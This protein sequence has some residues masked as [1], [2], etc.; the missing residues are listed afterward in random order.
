MADVTLQPPAGAAGE[1]TGLLLMRAWHDD[2]PRAASAP[3]WSDPRLGPRHQP[4]LGHPGRLPTVTQVPVRRPRGLVDL[5]ALRERLD[6][7][8][9]A[10]ML[11]NPNTLGLFEEDIVEIAAAVHEVGGLALLRRGQPQRH[12]GRHPPGRHGLRHRPLQPAQDLRRPPR[13]G[14]ARGRARWR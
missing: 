7:D 13:R 8:V 2:D 5:A 3:A 1:L 6:D 4:G 12:P 14:R 11:T 10:I 9:A